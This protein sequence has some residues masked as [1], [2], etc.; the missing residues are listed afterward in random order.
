[1]YELATAVT[2]KLFGWQQMRLFSHLRMEITLCTIMAFNTSM[3]MTLLYCTP[4]M[5]RILQEQPKRRSE[6]V[7]FNTPL[8]HLRQ[9]V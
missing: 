7:K 3:N 5:F 2:R 1:M 8:C 9:S 6:R 4:I